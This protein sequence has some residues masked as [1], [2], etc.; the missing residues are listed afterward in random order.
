MDE[1]STLNI[2][3]QMDSEVQPI[4]ADS[5]RQLIRRSSSSPLDVSGTFSV[6]MTPAREQMDRST[7]SLVPR[8]PVQS[9]ERRSEVVADS[10]AQPHA[11]TATKGPTVRSPPLQAAEKYPMSRQSAEHEFGTVS[12][13][14]PSSSQMPSTAPRPAQRTIVEDVSCGPEE[15]TGSFSC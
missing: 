14:L 13:P 2:S 1:S 8:P 6:A 12:R 15:D 10:A 9:M 5:V 3:A 7:G 4:T 11:P